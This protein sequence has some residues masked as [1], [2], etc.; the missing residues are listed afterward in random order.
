V[1][2]YSLITGRYCPPSGFLS[3]GK[4]QFVVSKARIWRQP[5]ERYSELLDMLQA[6]KDHWIHG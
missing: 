3:F 2:T 1:Q 4:G 6:E 5:K